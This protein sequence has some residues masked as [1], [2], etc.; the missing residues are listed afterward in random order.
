M[1]TAILYTVVS[2]LDLIGFA[3]GVSFLPAQVPIHFDAAMTADVVGSPW[4]YLALPG[5]AALISGGMWAALAQKKNRAITL[6]F[7]TALGI[8]F[9]TMGWV[10][11]ALVAGGVEVGE[12]AAFPFPLLIGLPLT[13]LL[14]WFGNYMPRIRPNKLLGI[15]TPA[16]LRSEEVWVKTHRLGG[17]LC[18]G[19]G[20]LSAVC[21]ILT[22]VIPA[23]RELQYI[24]VIVFGVLLLSA[25]AAS[26]I[27]A[28]LLA[29]K[30]APPEQEEQQNTQ[31]G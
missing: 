25:A 24:W 4:V 13:L 21:V 2:I 8:V 27:Y 6:S 14:A 19:A 31:E 17:Y 16:T 29:K 30:Q 26:V 28:H 5:A 9:A 3:I 1:K 18:F 15:R 10:F 11:F 20:I 22:G 23:L 7:L 12:K